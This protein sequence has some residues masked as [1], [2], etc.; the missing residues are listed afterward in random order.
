MNTP[1]NEQTELKEIIAA[2]VASG[3]DLIDAPAKLWIA[4]GGAP[5]TREALIAAIQQA[6]KECGSCGC[7]FDP[8]YKRALALQTLI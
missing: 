8:L 5:Q 1:A 2:F 6:D 7:D 4:S 3:W